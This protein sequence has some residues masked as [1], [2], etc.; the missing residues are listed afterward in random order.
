MSLMQKI[1]LQIMNKILLLLVS[2]AVFSCKKEEIKPCQTAE[3]L[4]TQQEQLLEIKINK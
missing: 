1:I 2:L 4:V 3:P